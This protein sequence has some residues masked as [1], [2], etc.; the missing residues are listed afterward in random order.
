MNTMREAS[1]WFRENMD[2]LDQGR[3]L[4]TL[5]GIMLWVPPEW[6]EPEGE[7]EAGN[8]SDADGGNDDGASN[9]A[10]DDDEGMADD[11]GQEFY[12]D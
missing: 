3:L 8:D 7:D 9:A 10:G 4:C 2:S 1:V 5:V 12:D 6:P 11:V